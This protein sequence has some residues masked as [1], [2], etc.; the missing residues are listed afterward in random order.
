MTVDP[1]VPEVDVDGLAAAIA[2]GAPV[3]DVR[4]PD[5]YAEAHAPGAVL[6]P[7][8]TVPDHVD[9]FRADGPVYIICQSGGRSMRASEFLRSQGVDAI[10]VAGGT[11]AWLAAGQPFESG[12][13]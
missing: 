6:I 2:G 12:A 8:A 4:Q 11:K 9:T 10:N 1:E 5:E 13:N 7:L 3:F